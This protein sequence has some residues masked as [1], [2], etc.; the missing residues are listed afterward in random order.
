MS[1]Q[2]WPLIA[3]A[4]GKSMA[5]IMSPRNRHQIW[6]ET[7]WTQIMCPQVPQMV[8]RMGVASLAL[9]DRPEVPQIGPPV[10]H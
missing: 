1:D 9:I 4:N 6:S 3:G 8:C 10:V 2:N 5:V 7:S